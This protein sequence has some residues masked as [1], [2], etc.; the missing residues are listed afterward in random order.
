MKFTLNVDLNMLN[1]TCHSS[2][3]NLKKIPSKTRRF[4]TLEFTCTESHY[5][6][7]GVGPTA[8]KS[9]QRSPSQWLPID[10]NA[11]D[12]FML[13]TEKF[14][15]SAER[16][17]R[18]ALA[19]EMPPSSSLATHHLPSN[20]SDLWWIAAFWT[21]SPAE[22]RPVNGDVYPFHAADEPLLATKW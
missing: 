17:W 3:Q 19:M 12:L 13:W 14:A 16:V 6:P 10:A 8:K 9:Q 7:E 18:P 4:K 15:N 22:W 1:P 21:Q 11:S 2:T 20:A 5:T